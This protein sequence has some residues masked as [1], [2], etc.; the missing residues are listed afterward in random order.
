MWRMTAW[1]T[2]KVPFRW[3][4]IIRSPSLLGE[5]E[6]GGVLGDPRAANESLHS[7]EPFDQPVGR[8][9]NGIMV[10]DVHHCCL[11]FP[12]GLPHGLGRAFQALGVQIE[13][14]DVEAVFAEDLRGGG[15]DT[16]RSASQNR[17]SLLVHLFSRRCLASRLTS[18]LAVP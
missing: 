17:D 7:A 14:A 5:L 6:K 16:T 11:R 8:D 9:P 10:Y 1:V 2:L 12:P 13:K 4:S 3:I 15:T 18:C